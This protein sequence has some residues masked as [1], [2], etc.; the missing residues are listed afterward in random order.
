MTDPAAPITALYYP[1]LNVN[2][3]WLKVS[4]LYWDRVRRIVPVEAEYDVAADDSEGAKLARDNELLINTPAKDYVETAAASFRKRVLPILLSRK[5]NI[6]KEAE[7]ILAM[8]TADYRGTFVH[9]DKL[10][11]LL[12]DELTESRL[13]RS[14]GDWVVLPNKMASLYMVCLASEMAERTKL[15]LVTDEDEFSPSG[16]YCL[17]GK[18]PRA[19]KDV[20][21]RDVLS[22]IGIEFPTADSVRDISMKK[23]L[24]FRAKRMDELSAFRVAVEKVGGI[25]TEAKS[26]VEAQEAVYA[27]K[28]EVERSLR[29]YKTVLDEERVASAKNAMAISVPTLLASTMLVPYVNLTALAATGLTVLAVAWWADH[30]KRARKAIMEC[31]WHYALSVGSLAKG[32]GASKKAGGGGGFR[33]RL[34]PRRRMAPKR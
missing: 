22:R 11:K 9:R 34:S 27:A 25:L 7:A 16:E 10:S 2:E 20:V 5:E 18:P 1:Y 4:L 8:P 31:Q 15:P 23:I 30:R 21:N 3:D 28:K 19:R 12:L 14:H 33:R 24:G 13:A 26:T 17:F 32:N 29:N 6:Q